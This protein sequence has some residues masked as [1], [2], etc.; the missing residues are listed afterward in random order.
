MPNTLIFLFSHGLF[1]LFCFI[2]LKCFIIDEFINSSQHVLRVV[3]PLFTKKQKKAKEE[4]VAL[5]L[6]ELHLDSF[7]LPLKSGELPE[8]IKQL[9]AIGREKIRDIHLIIFF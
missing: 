9:I 4:D 2:S 8:G 3:F 5:A 1:Q 6:K 7:Y